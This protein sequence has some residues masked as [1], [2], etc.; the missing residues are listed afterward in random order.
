MNAWYFNHIVLLQGTLLTFL[1]ALSVQVPLRFGVFSFAGVAAY[2]VGAYGTAILALRYS[3]SPFLALLGGV[4]VAMLGLAVL[5]VIVRRL[6]GMYLAM[7]TVSVILMLQVAI[8][9]GGDFTGGAVGLFGITSGVEFWQLAVLC[10]IVAGALTFTEVGA[11]GRR[12]SVVRHD[13][14]LAKSVGIVV[15]KYQFASFVISA[16]L[17]GAAGGMQVLFRTTV[18]PAGLGFDLMITAMTVAIIGGFTSWVGAAIGAVFVTWLPVVLESVD[19]YQHLIYGCL[20]VVA[21]VLFPNGFLGIV[22]GV[23]RGVRARFPRRG[24]SGGGEPGGTPAEEA[25]RTGEAGSADATG[26]QGRPEIV[27]STS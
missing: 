8:G 21:A 11:L 9:N 20:V 16:A 5:G 4:L 25:V 19:Q 10:V 1:L 14:E 12:I 18:S 13:R 2:G 17:G 15:G 26:V 6:S 7:A 3:W 22:T 24:G 23:S 27:S